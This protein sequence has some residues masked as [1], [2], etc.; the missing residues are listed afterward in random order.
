M[1]R[2][3]LSVWKDSPILHDDKTARQCQCNPGPSSMQ[4]SQKSGD[5]KGTKSKPVLNFSPKIINQVNDLLLETKMK[6]IGWDPL[7]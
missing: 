2:V 1:S 3:L 6:N 5:K 7:L 4:I